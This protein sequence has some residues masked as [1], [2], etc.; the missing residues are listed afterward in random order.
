VYEQSRVDDRSLIKKGNAKRS[1]SRQAR[2]GRGEGEK[3]GRKKK[4]KGA[5]PRTSTRE[6]GVN[7]DAK[8]I[9]DFL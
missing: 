7:Q 9:W 6:E 3:K 4:R 2:R 8:T 1:W 5:P